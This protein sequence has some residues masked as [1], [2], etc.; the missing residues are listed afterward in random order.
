MNGLLRYTFISLSIS[1]GLFFLIFPLISPY[2]EFYVYTVPFAL[3]FKIDRLSI[4]FVILIA[5]VSIF[6]SVFSLKYSEEYKEK[7]HIFFLGLLFILSM[8]LVVLSYDMVTFLIFWE[9]MSLT[10]FFLVISDGNSESKKAGRLYFLMT[11][12]GTVFITSAFVLLYLKSSSLS[13]GNYKDI[14]GILIL[15]LAVTGFSI[16]AGLLPFHAW[17]PHAHPVAPSH[18]SALMSGVMVNVAIYGILRFLFIFGLKGYPYLGILL[19]ILGALTAFFGIMNA[20]V[21]KD[22]KKTLAFS[23]IE[24][25]GIIYMGIG[26]SYWASVEGYKIIAVTALLAA[27]LHVLNHALSKSALFMGSGIILKNAHTKNMEE[28][29]GLSKKMSFFSVLFLIAAMSISAVPPLNGFLG[30]WYLYV[31]L[32]GAAQTHNLYIVYF[33]IIS[34]ALLSLTGVIAGAAFA[35]LYGIT[36]L[37]KHRSDKAKNAAKTG[38]IE[39]ISLS[40]PVLLCIVIGIYP[41]PLISVLGGL[42]SY[43]FRGLVSGGGILRAFGSNPFSALS[44]V[45]T[46]KN[47]SYSMYSPMLFITGILIFLG[48]AAMFFKI[49]SNGK[50]RKYKTW[51][52]GL[53]EDN[54]AAQFSGSGFSYGI[55]RVFSTF[56]STASEIKFDT[57]VKKYFRKDTV[58]S[59][60]ISDIFEMKVYEPLKK[61]IL[62]ASNYLSSIFETENMNLSL[63]YVFLSLVLCVIIYL[64]LVG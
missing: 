5:L 61:Y 11:H 40:F 51:D 24:N 48:L 36:F 46:Y 4:F 30:E 13:F 9:L 43:L 59:E 39:N 31:S 12:I 34:I 53:E 49:A 27:I 18:I 58:Y 19:L 56:Y 57:D 10:S 25:I 16:K 44:P 20:L 33:S 42:I 47:Y 29:G 2:K 52:C 37:G 26:L 28:L 8:I 38:L 60:E 35:K 55:M 15:L 21:Q 6:I 45:Q 17:L 62:K 7:P 14:A 1:A 63:S 3:T 41:Y 50:T 23:T 64:F 32:I 54:K 22:I